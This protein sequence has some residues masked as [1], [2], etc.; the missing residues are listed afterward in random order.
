[1]VH[2][3]K[4]TFF[5]NHFTASGSPDVFLFQGQLEPCRGSKLAMHGFLN[6]EYESEKQK[7]K[8]IE[9][10]QRFTRLNGTKRENFGRMK[11]TGEPNA[12]K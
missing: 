10:Y 6:I 3:T 5:Q 4:L 9:K 11:S 8:N 7:Q 2:R 1:M 12:V